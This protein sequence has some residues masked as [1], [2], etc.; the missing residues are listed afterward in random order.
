M[1]NQ[2][3][4]SNSSSSAWDDSWMDVEAEPEAALENIV[5]RPALCLRRA[6]YACTSYKG[7]IC[8]EG[9]FCPL[10]ASYP[11][12]CQAGFFCNQTGLDAPA[13]PCAPGFFCPKETSKG[14]R[15]AEQSS[16]PESPL[17]RVGITVPSVTPSSETVQLLCPG[18]LPSLSSSAS[19]PLGLLPPASPA[20]LSGAPAPPLLFRAAAE[21]GPQP[22]IRFG[23]SEL[24]RTAVAGV[25]EGKVNP[26]YS[27]DRDTFFNELIIGPPIPITPSASLEKVVSSSGPSFQSDTASEQS[28]PHVRSITTV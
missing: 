5:T 1:Y 2:T 28:G 18:L 8:P 17:D 12:L 22:N 20:A 13:G 21:A 9:F 25:R 10:G 26:G 3:F 15:R 16:R 24:G 27:N 14:S 19:L 4:L 23:Q 11:L 7:D 6:H